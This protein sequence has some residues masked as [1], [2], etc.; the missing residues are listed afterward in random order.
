MVRMQHTVKRETNQRF[1][2]TLW[3]W[4][5]SDRRPIL[6][7]ANYRVLASQRRLRASPM[8]SY[9]LISARTNCRNVLVYRTRKA[10][11]NIITDGRGGPTQKDRQLTP[12]RKT[13]GFKRNTFGLRYSRLTWMVVA[14]ELLAWIHLRPVFVRLVPIPVRKN[15]FLGFGNK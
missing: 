14:V 13:L 1:C 12:N 6:A 3:R 11:K 15:G 4:H 2:R 9:V 10:D 8:T 7:E 5:I